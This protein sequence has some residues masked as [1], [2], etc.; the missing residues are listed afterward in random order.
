MKES[1]NFKEFDRMKHPKH[2]YWLDDTLVAV[3]AVIAA[4]LFVYLSLKSLN[5]QTKEAMEQCQAAGNSFNT[6]YEEIYR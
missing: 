2:L 5:I 3:F 1:K 6:C 4:T